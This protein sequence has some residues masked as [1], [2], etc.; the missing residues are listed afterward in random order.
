MKLIEGSIKRPVAVVAAVL[1]VVLFGLIALS[2]IPIQLAPDVDRP[3]IEIT[4]EWYGAAPAELEREILNPQEEKLA[5]LEGLKNITGIA[6]FGRSRLTLEFAVGTNMERALLLVSNRLDRVTSYPSEAD[7]PT[8]DTKGSEDNAIAW[9]VVTLEGNNNRPV[10]TFG[11]FV[12]DVIKER[13]ERV[14]GVGRVNTYGGSEREIQIIVDPLELAQHN[15]GVAELIDALRQS[16]VSLSAGS[17]DEGK[18]QYTV[19]A[20]GDL[21]SPEIIRNVL[22]R[23]ERQGSA[24]GRITVGD[25]AQ[26]EF[27]YK[28]PV[29]RIRLLGKPAMALNAQRRHGANVI[30][31]MREIRL[32]VDELN[33]NVV[34]STGLRLQQVY[35]ET[36]Y[37]DS[38]INLVKQNIWIGGSLAA[39]MLL[40]FL[41][42]FRATLIVSISIP[43]SVIGAF[44]AMALLG[45]SINVV[46]LAGLAFAVGMVVDA[47]IVVL[48]NIYRLREQGYSAA[49]SA[50]E[51][52]KQ[53]WGA[54]LVSVLTTVLVFI[55]I[56]V[57]QLEAGQL[58]RDIA[59]AISVA[60][61]LSLLVSITVIPALSRHLFA[62]GRGS[63]RGAVYRLKLP[64][65]DSL[66]SLILRGFTGFSSF[67]GRSKSASLLIVS[68]IM[69][70]ACA[71]SWWFLPK[72]EYLPEGNRNLLFGIIIPPPGYNLETVNDIAE[73]IETSTKPY[74]V[75]Q[76]GGESEQLESG[77]PGMSRFFFVAT[78]S[79]TFLGAIAED[80]DRI[81]ELKP[82]LKEPAFSEPGTFGFITQP[83]IF[84]RGIG[85][86]R[87][88]E[89]DVSGPDLGIILDV[90]GQAFGKI[91]QTFPAEN[92][93]QW[94]PRP[95]LELGAPEV[96]VI[97]DRMRLTDVGISAREVAELIDVFNDGKRILEVTSEGKLID[98][99]LKG[100]DNLLTETQGV[101]DLPVVT[102]TGEIVPVKAVTEIQ[103]TSG[104]TAIRHRER[105]RT[106][107]LE[108]RPTED[109]TLE[110]AIDLLNAEV[111]EPMR[112]Q[113]LPQGIKLRLSG[114]ADKL[115]ETRDELSVDMIVALAIV[116]LV[117]AV[118]FES[119]VYP[120]IILLSVPLAAVGGIGGLAWIN[121]YFNQPL[122]MLTMLGFIILIGIVVNNAILLV[123]QTLYHVR[124]EHLAPAEAI[125]AA[126]RNRVR[127][128]FMSTLT[129]VIGMLPLVLFPGSGSE[130]Y[131]GLG[132]VV[133]GGLS[134]SAVITL[135]VVPPMMAIIVAPLEQRRERRMRAMEADGDDDCH[136]E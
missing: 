76:S 26:V 79:Q 47:A 102:A 82:I 19:R 36:V 111:I 49:R 54:V 136:S 113:G 67:A 31:T 34:P 48:E 43:V 131:R 133:V 109:I 81:G 11:D 83:S 25:I 18:R 125:A 71:A 51:G 58:F 89:L 97:P 27:N 94:R 22:I 72:L 91:I 52:A 10:H 90:A 33:K 115:L 74:W 84:G 32:A 40:L 50:F 13:L 129:S 38:A 124:K 130:L 118:L 16:S 56:L 110:S 77:Q 132:T 127:P 45:R 6:E 126:T 5:G 44:V 57:M 100:A 88:I 101:A 87:K 75:G 95:G 73:K 8:L 78:R 104:P 69:I 96:R 86:S 42:S 9:F 80:A 15:L 65:I 46:S 121:L 66:A 103:M 37:I 62:S 55:P 59:V 63:H 61:V 117:M 107:T 28:K 23:S 92:G 20:E 17:I 98:L 14:P 53:V 12:N 106:I 128:I 68:V 123:H 108:I 64:L 21:S 35:D 120:I 39:L 134:L 119:F 2:T 3:I 1:L 105:F 114:T 85:G 7:Q 116:Y 41:R 122:D 70:S 30:E 24:L 112:E 135:L 4:S 60:V 99:T 29:S 93:N